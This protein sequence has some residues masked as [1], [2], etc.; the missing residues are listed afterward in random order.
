MPPLIIKREWVEQ[1][2]AGLPELPGARRR[3]FSDEYGLSD[4][5]AD[6]LTSSRGMSEFFEC[7]VADEAAA[8]LPLQVRAK[9]MSNWLITEVNRLL[10]LEDENIDDCL[11]APGHLAELALI[12][13]SGALSSPLAKVTL[14]ECFRSGRTP[15]QVVEERGYVQVN[16]AGM[17]DKAVREA[18]EANAGAVADYLAGKE[19]AS[20]YLMGQVM[21]ISKGK[22]NP[23]LAGEALAKQLQAMRSA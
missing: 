19:T 2:R 23:S 17:I 8:S 13:Q 12:V 6:L 16:D 15:R 5:D 9:M 18:L 20:K 3:R 10:N 21:K 1:V 22:V 7:A 4:Y 11:L 14:E